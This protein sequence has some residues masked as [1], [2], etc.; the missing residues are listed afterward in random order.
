MHSSLL[1]TNQDVLNGVLLEESVID[2]Q[3]STTWVTPDVLDVLGLEGF[4]KN[5][6]TAQIDGR[7]R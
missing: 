6:A 3:D 4:D 5:F 2:V 1:V 7:R